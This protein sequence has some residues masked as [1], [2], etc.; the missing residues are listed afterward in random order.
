MKEALVILGVLP[1]A[2]VRPPL[3]PIGKEERDQ[4]RAAL[5]AASLVE[6]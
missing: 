3:L 1:R 6:A 5:Q 2:T 4:I